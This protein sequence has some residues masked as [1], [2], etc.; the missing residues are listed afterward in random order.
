MK[1][2]CG[3]GGGGATAEVVLLVE[4]RIVQAAVEGRR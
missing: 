3:L 1:L 2:G 4:G